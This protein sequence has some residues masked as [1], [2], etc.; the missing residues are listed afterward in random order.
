MKKK[1][2]PKTTRQ[3]LGYVV[4]EA[5][6]VCAAIGKTLRWGL[7][8]VNPELEPCEQETNRDWVLRELRD[9]TGAIEILEAELHDASAWLSHDP[10]S[11]RAIPE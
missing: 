5:G 1:Y 8:S 11:R 6:E 7:E 9:L 2:E 10:T 4:E 3:K